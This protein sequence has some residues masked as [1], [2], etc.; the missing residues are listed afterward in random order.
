MHISKGVN[1]ILS[2]IMYNLL[3][4]DVH[5]CVFFSSKNKDDDDYDNEYL[6]Y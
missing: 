3:Y 4:D 1:Y 5:N 2:F 6:L